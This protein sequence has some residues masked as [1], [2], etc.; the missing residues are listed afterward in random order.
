MDP[1]PST[2]SK[3]DAIRELVHQQ[4]GESEEL[5]QRINQ[6]SEKTTNINKGLANQPYS[7]STN[8]MSEFPGFF[9]KQKPEGPLYSEEMESEFGKLI[10]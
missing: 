3:W 4:E 2:N 1:E 9:S 5:N 6:W 8:T 7:S 10:H